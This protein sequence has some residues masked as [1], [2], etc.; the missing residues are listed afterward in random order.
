MKR[1]AAAPPPETTPS[2]YERNERGAWVPTDDP[3]HIAKEMTAQSLHNW[4][5]IK[6]WTYTQTSSIGRDCPEVFESD[7]GERQRQRLQ[8]ILNTDR[9][10]FHTIRAEGREPIGGDFTLS[11]HTVVGDDELG[12][13]IRHW[14]LR[15]GEG[16]DILGMMIVSPAVMRQAVDGLRAGHRVAIGLQM[17]IYKEAISHSFDEHWMAQDLYVPFGENVTIDKFS[18]DVTEEHG[19]VGNDPIPEIR[20]VLPSEPASSS[21]GGSALPVI[22]QRLNWALALLALIAGVLLLK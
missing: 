10:R 18:V 19:E 22:Q 8:L 17:P 6:A 15:D 2:T 5:V 13:H 3:T 7:R 14:P 20:A 1:G 11:L 9:R 16:D 21:P 12:G 4:F